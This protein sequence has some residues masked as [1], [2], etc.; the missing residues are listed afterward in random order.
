MA[1][2]SSLKRIL[3]HP[4]HEDI[5]ILLLDDLDRKIA[6]LLLLLLL[7]FILGKSEDFAGHIF[8]LGRSIGFSA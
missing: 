6:F 4:R 3:H 5:R 1:I 7:D 8:F 2:C